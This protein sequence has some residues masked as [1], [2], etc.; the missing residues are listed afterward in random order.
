MEKTLE[1]KT[2]REFKFSFKQVNFWTFHDLYMA[3]RVVQG[4]ITPRN[5]IELVNEKGE[6][7]N[8]NCRDEMKLMRMFNKPGVEYTAIVRGT[9]GE[10][11]W[12]QDVFRTYHDYVKYFLAGMG[13]DAR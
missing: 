12:Y 3:M 13:D 9:E 6:R 2:E 10:F 5:E 7:W 4:E 8:I 11:S 1:D